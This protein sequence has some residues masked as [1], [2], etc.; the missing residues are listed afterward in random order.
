MS[1]IISFPDRS[2][3]PHPAAVPLDQQVQAIFKLLD[4]AMNDTEQMIGRC[5]KE[6]VRARLYSHLEL[7]RQ[8]S[9][10]AQDRA[11]SVFSQMR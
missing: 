2:Q 10:Y 9:G 5:R 6:E 11:S 7:L 1:N 3:S 8:L 4:V